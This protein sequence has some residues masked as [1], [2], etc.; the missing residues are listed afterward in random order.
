MDQLPQKRWL[1]YA[2]KMM[3]VSLCA[4]WHSNNLT[5]EEFEAMVNNMGSEL[6]V[7]GEYTELL[8]AVVESILMMKH[9][10]KLKLSLHH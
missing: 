4:G 9:V 3:Q 8:E 2:L 1:F 5:A 7:A 6:H 10:W